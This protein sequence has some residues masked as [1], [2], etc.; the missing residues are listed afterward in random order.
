MYEEDNDYDQ[1]DRQADLLD[2]A[3]EEG[4]CIIPEDDEECIVHNSYEYKDGKCLWA[5]QHAVEDI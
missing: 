2:E 1:F 3:R 4:R 5:S